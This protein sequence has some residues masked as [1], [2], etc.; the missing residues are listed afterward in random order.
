M[1]PNYSD[2]TPIEELMMEAL[3]ARHLLGESSWIF[4]SR[5]AETAGL[6]QAKRLIY[7]FPQPIQA[8]EDFR[9]SLTHVGWRKAITYALPPPQPPALP[10]HNLLQD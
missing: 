4:S 1:R 9:A 2:L 6:L 3:A 10:W 5:L 7:T 8:D